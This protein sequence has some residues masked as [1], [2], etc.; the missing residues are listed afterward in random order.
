MTLRLRPFAMRWPSFACTIALSACART[1]SAVPDAAELDGAPETAV[2][3][4][5]MDNDIPWFWCNAEVANP[6]PP[7]GVRVDARRWRC[8]VDWSCRYVEPSNHSALPGFVACCREPTG[9]AVY[10]LCFDGRFGLDPL[11][12]WCSPRYG[13][14]P[15]MTQGAIL[16]PI[17]TSCQA[18]T[19][20][21]QNA[22]C[23]PITHPMGCSPP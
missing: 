16:C 6:P 10:S 23:D 13:P 8:P 1:L 7:S 17:G 19:D 5:M 11:N 22:C 21:S 14:S 20:N 4:P 18:T 15:V 3:A 9:Y 2:D 12:Q